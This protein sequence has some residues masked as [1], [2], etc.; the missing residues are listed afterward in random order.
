MRSTC[1]L[2]ANLTLGAAMIA[3]TSACGGSQRESAAPA[4]APFYQPDVAL[5]TAHIRGVGLTGG[6]MDI[7][8]RVYNPND[9]DLLSPRVSYR[10]LLGG[11]HVADGLANPDVVVPAHDSALVRIPA[12]FSYGSV[13]EA[14]R[15]LIN[16][17]ALEY[18]VLGRMTV[19]TPYGRFWFPYDRAGQFATLSAR[20]P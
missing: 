4:P 14:G 20:L 7:E 5:R 10:I 15:A 18:R 8:M 17:G 16:R 12:T 13:G 11:K 9:Y 6:A 2:I 1:N 3:G 19:G